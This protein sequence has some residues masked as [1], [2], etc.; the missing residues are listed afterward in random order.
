M[1]RLNNQVDVSKVRKLEKSISEA[2]KEIGT[3]GMIVRAI[4]LYGN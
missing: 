1:I 3:H 4:Y 2:V